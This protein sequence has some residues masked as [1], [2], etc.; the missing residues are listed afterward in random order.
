M[1]K[2]ELSQRGKHMRIAAYKYRYWLVFFL[3]KSSS[4]YMNIQTVTVKICD[5]YH[6]SIFI[7][8]LYS[9]KITTIWIQTK[10]HISQIRARKFS[11]VWQYLDKAKPNKKWIFCSPLSPLSMT[12]ITSQVLILLVWPPSSQAYVSSH[13]ITFWEVLTW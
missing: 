6:S 5:F 11:I 2:V 9:F 1:Q 8:Y 12:L 13:F 10:V 7:A 4:V 3:L